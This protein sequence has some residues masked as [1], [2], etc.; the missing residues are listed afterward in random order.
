[1]WHGASRETWRLLNRQ[2][3]DVQNRLHDGNESLG[4]RAQSLVARLEAIEAA[5]VAIKRETPCDQER[6]PPGLNDKL[7]DLVNVVTMADAAP[8]LQAVLVS[9]EI[10]SKVDVETK[11]LDALVKE[12]VTALAVAFKSAGIELLG[13]GKASS[14]LRENTRGSFSIHPGR[15]K[16]WISSGRSSM[17]ATARPRCSTSRLHLRSE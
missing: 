6:N 3:A 9:D 15:R 1:M 5:L 2:L 13:I 17:G 12:E 7:I 8:T 4:E 11:R 10:M 14:G 16:T